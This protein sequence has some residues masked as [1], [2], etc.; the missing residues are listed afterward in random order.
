[1]KVGG[2]L[3]VI[4]EKSDEVCFGISESSF[5]SCVHS[6]CETLIR[7]QMNGFKACRGRRVPLAAIVDKQQ[8]MRRRGRYA[9]ETAFGHRGLVKIENDGSRAHGVSC[10]TR[11][12][13]ARYFLPRQ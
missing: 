8:P 7:R 9:F 5:Q 6:A 4:R 2:Q 13:V 11:P 1:M 3:D 12:N 10:S